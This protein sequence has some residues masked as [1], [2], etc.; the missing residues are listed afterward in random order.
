MPIL[1]LSIK[2]SSCVR[3]DAGWQPSSSTHA[4]NFVCLQCLQIRPGL[5]AHQAWSIRT[6][7][8]LL[9][10][11]WRHVTGAAK[12]RSV[13]HMT[14]TPETVAGTQKLTH[15]ENVQA[16]PHHPAVGAADQPCEPSSTQSSKMDMTYVMFRN[17]QPA[18]SP[19]QKRK[20]DQ[21]LVRSISIREV[22]PFQAFS[23]LPR[24]KGNKENTPPSLHLL[25]HM[26][27]G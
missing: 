11:A 18:P 26:R 4:G 5:V 6:W 22:S 14:V 8:I 12:R 16:Q 7:K 13:Q 23:S 19:S 25:R 27:V 1:T 21:S 10:L 9:S 20:Q 3:P 2:L 17:S 15:R 24:S